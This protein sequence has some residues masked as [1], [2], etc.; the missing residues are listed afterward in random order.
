MSNVFFRFKQFTVYH[1]LCAMK[2]GTDGVLLGAWADCGDCGSILDVGTGSGLI[3]LMTAQR[4]RAQIDALDIDAGAC[5]QA[6]VNVER[7][8]FSSRIRVVHEDYR[9]F[10]SEDLYDLIVSNPPYFS[11]SPENPDDR[12]AKARHS[13]S[14]SFE[15]L[16]RKSSLLLRDNGKLAVIV[17]FEAR[18]TWNRQTLSCRLSLLRETSVRSKPDKPPKRILL[19][20]VKGKAERVERTELVI[21]RENQYT[22]EY[23]ALT[24]AFYL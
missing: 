20:Y 1:D 14:L 18:T 23:I 2:V 12:K 19:E 6:A 3:A 16:V 10:H 13:V 22:P 21:S 11:L 17:P 5:K 15:E 8:P 9:T 4:S 24:G 7:S